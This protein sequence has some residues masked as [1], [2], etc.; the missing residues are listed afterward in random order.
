MKAS[1]HISL[2]S[3]EYLVLLLGFALGNHFTYDLE[4][5]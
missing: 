4:L 1:D 3:Y 5:I 2:L